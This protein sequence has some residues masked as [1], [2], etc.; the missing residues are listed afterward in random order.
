MPVTQKTLSP[1]HL[2]QRHVQLASLQSKPG[3]P[4]FLSLNPPF[5]PLS[6]NSIGR[7]TRQLLL[8]LGVP[9]AIF[10]PHSTRGAAVKMFK[11]L[12]LSSE[13]VCELGQWKNTEAFTKHYLRIGGAQ[14]AGSFFLQ[15]VGTQCTILV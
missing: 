4:V 10:G 9:M 6:A 12:G 2:V 7:I 13:I 15:K 11:K 14:V 5:Q 3:G 8:R 1:L